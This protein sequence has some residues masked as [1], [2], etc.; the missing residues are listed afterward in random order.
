MV[1]EVVTVSMSSYDIQPLCNPSTEL[2][3]PQA[4]KLSTSRQ[5][6]MNKIMLTRK[7]RIVYTLFGIVM[8]F[9]LG[10]YF[11]TRGDGS[12][13][14]CFRSPFPEE[15]S[16]LKFIGDAIDFGRSEEDPLSIIGL[17]DSSA[18][19]HNNQKNLLFVGVITAEKYLATRAVAVYKTWGS[20]IPGKIAFFSSEES[21]RPAN[22][23]DLPL[24]S[25]PNVDDSYPPQKKSFLML[26]YMWEKYG[27]HFEWFFRA[28]DD[29]YIRPDK[30]EDLLRSL[31]SK[32]LYFIGQAGKGNP[33]E[34]GLL[35]LEEDENFCMGGPG[36][37]MSRETLSR[38]APHIKHC[39]HN[40]FTTHED[41]EVG[42]CVQK[43]AGVPCTWAYNVSKI[44]FM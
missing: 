40:L 35:S 44:R 11:T 34:F 23:P 15:P 22:M 32:K 30:I 17:T 37:I 13:R 9:T 20:D 29:V 28:D 16:S 25:L 31:D 6:L 5:K 19:V 41:V 26:K 42:R 2:V 39:L 33:E 1:V 43:F 3:Q 27:D 4:T 10:A 14:K 18:N 38:M 12:E 7:Y 21:K 24:V 36:M 8:G